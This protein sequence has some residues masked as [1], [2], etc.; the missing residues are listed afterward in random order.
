MQ[1]SFAGDFY[2]LTLRWVLCPLVGVEREG[3]TVSAARTLIS[4]RVCMCG[5]SYVYSAVMH[6]D[7]KIICVEVF[8]LSYMFLVILWVG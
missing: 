3:P 8:L 1:A 4:V 2:W 5:Y 7:S 6:N